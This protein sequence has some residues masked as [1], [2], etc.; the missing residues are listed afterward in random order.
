MKFVVKLS[1]AFLKSCTIFNESLA[2]NVPC[3]RSKSLSKRAEDA[4]V[5]FSSNLLQNFCLRFYFILLFRA[6]E[7]WASKISDFASVANLTLSNWRRKIRHWKHA[8]FAKL[9]N[10]V[11][12]NANVGI[13]KTSTSFTA[14]SISS[15][16]K[17]WVKK[18]KKSSMKRDM[19]L[20]GVLCR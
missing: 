11:D 1:K 19:M 16:R 10:I 4:E 13:S 18:P 14:F 7:K 15:P 2:V 8:H 9:L 12:K 20:T 5:F 6:E 3:P 17:T